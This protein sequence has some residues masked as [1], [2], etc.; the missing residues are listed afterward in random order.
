MYVISPAGTVHHFPQAHHI[1]ERPGGTHE[2]FTSATDGYWQATVPF[3]W[4]VCAGKPPAPPT[5][6]K[7]LLVEKW[8]LFGRFT[9]FTRSPW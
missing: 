8:R 7:N 6:P 5:T 4:M 2:L 3:G 9:I 1:V